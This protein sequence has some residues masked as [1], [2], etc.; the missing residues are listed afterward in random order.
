MAPFDSTLTTKISPIIDEQTPDFV[1]TDH[2][3]FVQLLKD[4]YKFLESAELIITATVDHFLQETISTQFILDE[5]GE[6]VVTETG[7]GTSGKFVA[8]ETITGETSNATSTVLVDDMV[9]NDRLFIT[10]Q[11]RFIIGETI[12]GSTS[13]ATAVIKKYRGN[14]VQNIQQLLDLRDPDN[15]VDNFLTEM[16]NQFVSAVPHT[17]ASGLSKRNLIKNIRDLYSA[18]GTSEG[19]KLFL[20]L[21]FDEEGEI[22]YP[23]RFMARAS[24]AEWINPTI[25]R[26][27]ANSG[28][29]GDAITGQ[30]ITGVTSGAIATVVSATAFQQG[31]FSVTELTVDTDSISGTFIDGET[32]NANSLT[33]DKAMSFVVNQFVTNMTI[34]NDG[35]LYRKDDAI[36][37]DSSVGNGFAEAIVEEVGTGKLNAVYVEDGGSNYKVGDKLTFTP[38]ATWDKAFDLPTGQV[39]VVGGS[40]ILEDNVDTDGSNDYIIQETGTTT[41]IKY[42]ILAL[43]GTNENYA[44]VGDAIILE[45]T[46]GASTDEND[47]ILD[48]THYEVTDILADGNKQIVLEEASLPTSDIGKITKVAIAEPGGG[49]SRMPEVSVTSATGTGA[50]LYGGTD[51]I[52]RVLAVRLKDGGFEYDETPPVSFLARF[53]LRNINGSFT[54]GSALSTQPGGIVK[55]FDPQTNIL[56]V[57][58]TDNERIVQETGGSLTP[59]F[60]LEEYPATDGQYLIANSVIE[61]AETNKV[62][63]G[64]YYDPEKYM[65]AFRTGSMGVAL[66]SATP[67]APGRMRREGGSYYGTGPFASTMREVRSAAN[68]LYL[69]QELSSNDVATQVRG[70]VVGGD[71]ITIDGTDADSTDEGS[72]ILLEDSILMP[73]LAAGDNRYLF[74]ETEH[75]QVDVIGIDNFFRD[76]NIETLFFVTEDGDRLIS[77]DV[78]QQVLLEDHTAASP[79]FMVGETQ[80]EALDDILLDGTDTSGKD[81]DSFLVTNIKREYI[82]ENIIDS[83]GGSAVIRIAD[84]ASA[85]PVLGSISTKDGFFSTTDHQISE[86][87]VRLQD[88]YYY[89][90]FS[91]EVKIGQST[92]DYLQE[93]KGTVHPAGF[94]P[95]GKVNL[96]TSVA[97]NINIPTAGHLIDYTGDT[98]TFTPELASILQTA[99]TSHL[100]RRLGVA[101]DYRMGEGLFEKIILEASID[102][103]IQIEGAQGGYVAHESA[104][105]TPDADRDVTLISM[106]T[107]KMQLPKPNPF[108]STGLQYVNATGSDVTSEF[109]GIEL[110]DGFRSAGP[111]TMRDRLILDG[112]VH[113]HAQD[114]VADVGSLMQLEDFSNPN[115]DYSVSFNDIAYKD[116]FD[117]ISESGD[118]LV[119][120]TGAGGEAVVRGNIRFTTEAALVHTATINDFVRPSQILAEDGTVDTE[121]IIPEDATDDQNEGDSFRMEDNSGNIELQIR[122]GLQI[123]GQLSLENTG[124]Q[125]EDGDDEGTFQPENKEDS[126]FVTFTRPSK[127]HIRSRGRVAIQDETQPLTVV[128]EDGD[129]L[130]IDNVDSSGLDAG[131][132]IIGERG[133]YDLHP[134]TP[135]GGFTLLETGGYMEFEGATYNTLSGSYPVFVL[136]KPETFDRTDGFFDSEVFTF[137]RVFG[138]GGL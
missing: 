136:D 124:F 28:S 29:S 121:K 23:N 103:R 72:E 71:R 37:L 55:A 39:T 79:S 15:T 106:M 10:S 50:N 129:N 90:D 128:L 97:A 32:I 8:N 34:T 76:G 87:T 69:A 118:N 58:L 26:C 120:E 101:E 25:I 109:G 61:N 102:G 40:F 54:I 70:F 131:E 114:T 5:V 138:D 47:Y 41:Y 9:N 77:E 132:N 105:L 46:D 30:K 130:L 51:D 99:F 100:K 85:T 22:T 59:R 123:G 66:E 31:L 75:P 42:P 57:E 134:E 137:D 96:A 88:S 91:Y 111:T 125:L 62:E 1:R 24:K 21:L 14:P 104:A 64:E 19:H 4:Y 35:I 45:G 116:V 86:F 48:E 7:T 74:T 92:T 3:V 73:S 16:V 122:T 38:D 115:I 126:N 53:I 44:N 81:A 2:P 94:I 112:H 65:N 18:K 6:K 78:G 12:T 52:G 95:F 119:M 20:R 80:I 49:F 60:Q 36:I 98:D 67:G 107:A 127:I 11:Q 43:N 84:V 135:E 17:M 56:T 108:S 68:E 117:L 63:F 82:N 133:A 110:E 83:D 27:T 93:L 13:G 89:Q 113:E 33:E